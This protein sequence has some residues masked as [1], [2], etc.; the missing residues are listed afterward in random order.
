[1]AHPREPRRGEGR[2]GGGAG[3][4]GESPGLVVL[5][6]QGGGLA[7]QLRALHLLHPE[8]LQ[9][10]LQP[11]E[12]ALGR[13][14]DGQGPHVV[15]WGALCI[16]RSYRGEGVGGGIPPSGWKHQ[17]AD[18]GDGPLQ[19]AWQVGPCWSP[20]L[21]AQGTLHGMGAQAASPWPSD[22]SQR[23][24]SESQAMPAAVL[25]NLWVPK[26]QPVFPPAW[27]ETKT[28]CRIFAGCQDSK[29]KPNKSVLL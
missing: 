16:H 1:M 23:I 29:P 9:Q 8:P 26:H 11:V 22:P 6:A 14:G 12:G 21:A 10:L 4:W 3:G 27:V 7:L 15:P 24:Q 18:G 25:A 28:S 20:C 17:T 5:G 2:L 13:W 19:H